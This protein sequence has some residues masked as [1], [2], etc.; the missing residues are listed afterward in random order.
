MVLTPCLKVHRISFTFHL[1]PSIPLGLVYLFF[2]IHVSIL[3]L[4][5]WSKFIEADKDNHPKTL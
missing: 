2:H 5:F 4:I 1:T 3:C